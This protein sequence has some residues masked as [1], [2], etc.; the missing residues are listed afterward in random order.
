M[1]TNLG[2]LS[3]VRLHSVLLL[4][5]QILLPQSVDGV[6]HDLDQLDLRVSQPVLVGDVVGVASLTPGLS[7]GTT[8]LDG[9]L[10]TASL[11]LVHALLGPAGQ[12]HVDGGSHAGAEVGGAGVD[13]AVL[14]GQSVVLAG[15]SLHGLLDSLDAAGQASEDSLDVTA[16]LH[17]DDAG[18]VLLVD[19]EQEG[20]GVVVEDA[21]TLGPVTLHTSNLEREFFIKFVKK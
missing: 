3:F 19:P 7:T 14:L 20:L 9:Q 15:L 8:G 1:T 5:L 21:T 16:L 4:E 12:V 18:L 13:V 2:K 17:G 6:N 10:L 11:Q